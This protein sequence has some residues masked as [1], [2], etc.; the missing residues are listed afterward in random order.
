MQRVTFN[1]FVFKE[2]IELRQSPRVTKRSLLPEGEQGGTHAGHVRLR[3]TDHNKSRRLDCEFQEHH[4]Q[5]KLSDLDTTV[6]LQ[7]FLDAPRLMFA[8]Q[9]VMQC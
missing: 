2:T 1:F 9:V 7:R 3:L 5:F 8:I 4:L 6:T